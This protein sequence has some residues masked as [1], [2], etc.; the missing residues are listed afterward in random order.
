MVIVAHP[1]DAD[2]GPAATAAR[3]I[4]AGSPGWLVCCTSGD[5]GGED[6]D[7]DPLELAAAP[8]GRAAGGRGR[9]R[10][11]RRDVPAPARRRARQRPR[12]AR[13][14]R[15]R[16]P[17]V[18]PGRRPRDRS[19]GRSSTSDGGVNHT[20]HRAAGMAAVD[21]VYPA[22][23][24]PM[25]FPWP[26]A[27]AGSAAHASAGSTC[28]GRTDADVLGRRR[29]P[30]S[31]ARSRR[32]A[33]TPARSSDPDGLAEPDPRVG[34][35]G[36]RADRRRRRGGV[37]ARDRSTTTRTRARSADGARAQSASSSSSGRTRAPLVPE[38]G[39]AVGAP[40]RASS[41]SS[42]RV[43]S[44]AALARY[45]SA[46]TVD[47]AEELARSRPRSA[48]GGCASGRGRRSRAPATGRAAT[49]TPLVDPAAEAVEAI[50][51][52]RQGARRCRGT[53]PA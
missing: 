5:Q 25:A 29:R 15:P 51:E 38:L 33:P 11:R 45:S 20:D 41:T 32:C 37:P 36:G 17:D 52:R 27:I 6:P 19:R 42:P 26:G 50:A 35:R 46:A 23:R 30:R 18:P 22:A 1:D 28:S 9:H 13:A 16:D 47:L 48:S 14:A 21:A 34:G 2:F 43:R 8:R 4:D 44:P 31:S 24:N 7:A 40:A 49:G 53:G 10:L 3:W 39:Q 12:P